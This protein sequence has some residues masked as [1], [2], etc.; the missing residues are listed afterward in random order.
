MQ[1]LITDLG[2]FPSTLRGGGVA[3]GNFDAVHVGHA[4]LI[5]ELVALCSEIAAPA[6]VFT[7][8]PPPASIL[9]PHVLA[10]PALTWVE[11][12]AEVLFDLG[13]DAVIAY[14][15][16]RALLNLT[17]EQFFRNIL[18]EALGARAVVEGP[19]F[20]FGKDRRGNVE[21]L[22]TLCREY[23]IV[24]RIVEPL[25]VGTQ[26]VSSTRIRE[27]IATGQIGLANQL[28]VRPYR[29]CGRVSQG[30]GRGRQLGFPTA[31]LESIPVLVPAPGV[32]AGAAV[33]DNRRWP[34]AINIGPNPTF[35]ES[36]MKVEA[37]VIGW[38]ESIYDRWLEVEL[39]KRIRDVRKFGSVEDLR[40]Q[41]RQD[42]DECALAFSTLHVPSGT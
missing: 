36:R 34:A 18:V 22:Q 42:V 13:V 19:N 35:A 3:I 29:L 14:P 32:Y 30:A 33:I 7:F 41:I 25:F 27:L 2:V 8:D 4:A 28:L 12:R 39:L 38:Q 17:A 6:I 40:S 20:M 16:D 11:R 37:H 15:T 9:R 5:R 24:V 23:G 21:I 10:P 1:Q 31:N 26:L